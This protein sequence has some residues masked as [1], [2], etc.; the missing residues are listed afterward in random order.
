MIYPTKSISH[1]VG[2]SPIIPEWIAN[3]HKAQARQ[4]AL[5]LDELQKQALGEDE[6]ASD[7]IEQDEMDS[8]SESTV[9][10]EQ[11]TQEDDRP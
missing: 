3:Q 4:L 1:F 2:L 6:G 8:E 9:D 7:E 10:Q 11:D 5:E